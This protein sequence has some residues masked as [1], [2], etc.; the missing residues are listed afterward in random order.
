M[1]VSPTYIYWT[2]VPIPPA[3]PSEQVD[4]SAFAPIPVPQSPEPPPSYVNDQYEAP[5]KKPKKIEETK[6]SHSKQP[7]DKKVVELNQAM[8]EVFDLVRTV[9]EEHYKPSKQLEEGY[10]CQEYCPRRREV[11]SVSVTVIS[12]NTWSSWGPSFVD[13]RRR[14][15]HSSSDEGSGTLIRILIGV[16]AVVVAIAAVVLIAKDVKRNER[17]TQA[18]EAL[19]HLEDKI[20]ELEKL[21]PKIDTSKPRKLLQA[22]DLIFDKLKRDFRWSI[23]TKSALLVGAIGVAVAVAVAAWPVIVAFA[24]VTALSLLVILGRVVYTW[25]DDK[26][27]SNAA[28]KVLSPFFNGTELLPSTL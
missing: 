4:S 21:D 18:M 8:T 25:N 23:I 17:T 22:G 24:A 3:P 12:V 6:Y 1:T 26:N 19:N 7:L 15:R 20:N 14:S 16:V 5:L 10:F 28:M 27:L 11:S 2:P 13:D 9:M